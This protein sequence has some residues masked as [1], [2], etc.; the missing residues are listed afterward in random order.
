MR[1]YRVVGTVIGLL[2][3]LAYALGGLARG[4]E[5]AVRSVTPHLFLLSCQIL[6]EIVASGASSL[7]S[8]PVIALVPL[9]YSVRRISIILHWIDDVWVNQT[10]PVE[11]QVK[12]I[13]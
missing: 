7:F 11:A 5:R 1:V 12:V 6:T 4:D 10:L 13:S 2:L 9:L 8:P 3:P